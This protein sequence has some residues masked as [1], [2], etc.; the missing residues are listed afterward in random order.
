[1]GSTPADKLEIPPERLKQVVEQVGSGANRRTIARAAIDLFRPAKRRGNSRIVPIG[2]PEI[3]AEAVAEF[4]NEAALAKLDDETETE[5]LPGVAIEIR[6]MD[7]DK[8]NQGWAGILQVDGLDRRAPLSLFET[9]DAASLSAC[10]RALI[11][12]LVEF[13]PAPDGHKIVSRI[14]ILRVHRCLEEAQAPA[15]P[16]AQ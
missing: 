1:M 5:V 6:A 3:S 14:H 9:V 4:P 2:A 13:K 11:D 8:R 7:R 12:A 15:A 10:A 16:H